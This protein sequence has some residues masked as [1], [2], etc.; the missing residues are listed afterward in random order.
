M[1]TT[2]LLILAPSGGFTNGADIAMNHQVLYLQ[3]L[4]YEIHFARPG[5]EDKEFDEFLRS[6]DI[7]PLLLEY[8][9]WDNFKLNPAYSAHH[10]LEATMELVKYIQDKKI[11]LV[12]SNTLNI[13]WGALA[14]A[15]ANI[16]HIWLAHEFP[17]NEFSY[18]Q[19]RFSFLAR[20]TNSVMAASPLL[21]K[22]LQARL[23]EHNPDLKVGQF[24]PYTEV[25]RIQLSKEVGSPRFI[26]V[27]AINPRKN[28]LEI[29]QAAQI[30]KATNIDFKIVFTGYVADKTYYETMLDYI[31]KNN[32][33]QQISFENDGLDNWSHV[34]PTDIFVNPSK[35]ETFSLTMV[36]GLKLGL[37]MIVAN[38]QATQAM[39]ELKYIDSISVYEVDN[40]KKLAEKMKYFL[41]N[42]STIQNLS[43]QKSELVRVEQDLAHC[44]EPLL[45]EI[46]K[47]RGT[48]HPLYELQNLSDYFVNGISEY[49]DF[50]RTIIPELQKN[51]K[52]VED[53][54][55][56]R[57][58][59]ILGYERQIKLQTEKLEMIENSRSYKI[60]LTLTSPIRKMRK[61][62][63]K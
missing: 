22:L 21:Q 16:P 41:L 61:L 33:C 62:F 36:E 42:F 58:E 34:R 12:I 13:P 9:Y 4:G 25:S 31:E 1:D 57:Q 53:L 37:P 28:Q 56:A 51:F 54:A 49:S 59:V 23:G 24:Y 11:D 32:L 18:L 46:E 10:D 40:I 2:R 3:K 26:C 48:N 7:E 47:L 50:V 6:H 8:S 5:H 60:G 39:E 55:L 45:I 14:S 17:E 44:T 52:I 30:L 27:N 38:N 20:G 15:F 29:L 63:K 43:V 35:M 19:G